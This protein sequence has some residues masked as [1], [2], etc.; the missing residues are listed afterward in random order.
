MTR[1]LVLAAALLSATLLAGCG[2][3]GALERPGALEGQPAAS[4]A[5]AQVKTVDPRDAAT[6]PT[7]R[8]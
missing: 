2:K 8:P 3:L 7:P 6:L 1:P 4:S 5:P